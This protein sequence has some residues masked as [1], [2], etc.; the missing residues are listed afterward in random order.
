MGR[1][2]AAGHRL[3]TRW[4]QAE[5]TLDTRWI[6]AGYRLDARW[7][8]AGCAG[9][10]LDAGWIQ[11]GYTGYRLDT[12]WIQA[13][14]KLDILDTGWIQAGYRLD[15]GWIQAGYRLDIGASCSAAR[16]ACAGASCGGGMLLGRKCCSAGRTRENT[17]R[18]RENRAGERKPFGIEK[19]V[20]KH[21]CSE[22]VLRAPLRN[23]S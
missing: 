18:K 4:T 8:Q 9:Y 5:C 11:A 22:S 6:Q 21:V 15:I 14:Y 2:P 7:I 19:P 17:V 23:G 12:G 10:T 1:A 3:D 20:T 16:G 13:G